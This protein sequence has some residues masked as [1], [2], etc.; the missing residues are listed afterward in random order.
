MNNKI[1]N[2]LAIS[3][4]T[5]ALFLS[6]P[7]AFAQNAPSQLSQ[8]EPQPLEFD[9]GSINSTG[10]AQ[11]PGL[12]QQDNATQSDQHQSVEQ[13]DQLLGGLFAILVF[14]YILLRI[15]QRRHRA[16]IIL[17]QIETLE[18]IWHMEHHR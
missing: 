9:L 11:I 5:A 3:L 1:F 6:V 7:K 10:N 13:T 18:R 17:L 4:A 2:R 16:T 8:K 15:Q 14:S 12:M